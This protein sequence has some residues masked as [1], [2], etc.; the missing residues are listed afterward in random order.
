M[1]RHYGMRYVPTDVYGMGTSLDISF[2][3]QMQMQNLCQYSILDCNTKNNDFSI[4]IVTCHQVFGIVR[5]PCFDLGL[6]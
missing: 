6:L 2:S 5:V 3:R 4:S 1:I